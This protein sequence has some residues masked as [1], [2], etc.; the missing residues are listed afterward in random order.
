MV[1]VLVTVAVILTLLAISMPGYTKVREHANRLVCRSNIRQIGYAMA[2]YADQNRD[3]LPY[4]TFITPG[5]PLK[6]AP[7][8]TTA[9]R[10]STAE[11][12]AGQSPWDGVGILFDQGF[13]PAM[14]VFFCPSYTGPDQFEAVAVSF[15][16]QPER[17]YG[18]YQFRG[19][20]P[21]GETRL[22]LIEPIRSALLTD[23]LRS[24][25]DYSHRS[26]ANVLR[27]DL[28]VFWYSDNTGVI[29]KSLAEDASASVLVK[30]AVES[31]WLKLDTASSSGL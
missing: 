11:S 14:K 12:L 9:L 8:D 15:A 18:N 22:S 1:D 23:S 31:A 25:A 4:T 24:Q 30:P 16:D 21:N 6:S 17:V 10:L 7:Q 26:G 13:L 5:S 29:S 19:A 3:R 27:A 2:M 28:S 20:G